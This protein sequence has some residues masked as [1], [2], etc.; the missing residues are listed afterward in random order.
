[1]RSTSRIKL[2]GFA[3]A[4]ICTQAQAATIIEAAATPSAA[5]ITTGGVPVKHEFSIKYYN[6]EKF[7]CG[8]RL[9]HSDGSP[10][11]L[12]AIKQPEIALSRQKTYTQPGQ[13]TLT[14]E[15]HAHGGMVACLGSKTSTATL[16]PKAEQKPAASQGVVKPGDIQGFNPQPEP[17]LNR[18]PD[19]KV[20]SGP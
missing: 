7:A 8:A 6:N 5:A 1:M 13:H 12:V 3:L 2:L 10:V 19:V 17:P 18:K 15:G 20:K 14:L 16:Q 9:S 11:E 4:L